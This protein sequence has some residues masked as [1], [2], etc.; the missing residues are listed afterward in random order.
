MTSK[1]DAF[2]LQISPMKIMSWPEHIY[3][4]RR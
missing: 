3:L 1:F 2:Y 4:V